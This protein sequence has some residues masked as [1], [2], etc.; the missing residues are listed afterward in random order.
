MVEA[1]P[2]RTLRYPQGGGDLGLAEAGDPE[3][4]QHEA[5]FEGQPGHRSHDRIT[6]EVSARGVAVRARHLA[7]QLVASG[8][9]A[10]GYGTVA[11]IMGLENILDLTEGWRATFSQWPGL[12]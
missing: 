12:A 10:A 4:R 3:Q 7:L 2:D 5:M 9:S 1:G 8:L 6:F 11:T